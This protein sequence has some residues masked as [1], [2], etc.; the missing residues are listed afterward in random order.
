MTELSPNI[1]TR[2]FDK[3]GLNDKGETYVRTSGEGTF[4]QT[5]LKLGGKI[6]ELDINNTTWTP[7]TL[8]PLTERNQINIQNES[9]QL[10][11]VRYDNVAGFV[12][13]YIKT[14]ME[15]QYTVQGTIVMYFKS[16]ESAC[17]IVIEE[18]A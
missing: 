1:N 3:F 12:G 9:G 6:T 16:E 11:K 18:L 10:V 17:K 8:T 2:E 13:A 7:F 15:R 14:G 5:G 4:Q